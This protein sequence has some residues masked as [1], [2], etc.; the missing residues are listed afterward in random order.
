QWWLQRGTKSRWQ[1][2]TILANVTELTGAFETGSL[3]HR[4][5]AGIELTRETTKNASY[6]VATRSGSACPASL[7]G[8]ARS[9][10]DCT[11]LYHPNPNDPWTGSITRNPLSLDAKSTTQAAY[12]LDSI[13]LSEQFRV[14]AGIRYDRYRI[15]GE[16]TVGRGSTTMI[17]G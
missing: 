14:D 9:P 1:K 17:P 2:S 4:F 12:F 16:S 7:P 8:S 5:N 13:E 6:N 3:K 10:F 15:S 11:P